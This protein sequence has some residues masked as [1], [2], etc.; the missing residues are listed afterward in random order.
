[1]RGRRRGGGKAG[2]GDS[3]EWP[4]T[5]IGSRAG[6]THGDARGDEALRVLARLLARQAAREVF[7]RECAQTEVRLNPDITT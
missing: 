2:P 5:R 3:C 4:A 6:D 7:E 1:M